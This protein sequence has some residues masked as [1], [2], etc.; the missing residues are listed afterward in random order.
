MRFTN[1]QACRT[2]AVSCLPL[3]EAVALATAF[4]DA[5]LTIT[6]GVTVTDDASP[7]VVC[8]L[9]DEKGMLM[10]DS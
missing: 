6:A 8:S 10:F 9:V 3:K 5:E 4:T 7:V 1:K 2:S